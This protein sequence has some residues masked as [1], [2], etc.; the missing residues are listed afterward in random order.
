MCQ[1]QSKVDPGVVLGLENRPGRVRGASWEVLGRNGSA[2]SLRPPCLEGVLGAKKGAR[3]DPKG[4]R[5]GR[6]ETQRAGGSESL[7]RALFSAS[8]LQLFL[9]IDFFSISGWF[10]VRF[11]EGKWEG[12]AVKN[13]AIFEVF[14]QCFF[15]LCR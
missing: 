8:S 11:G 1:N 7:P 2:A 12:K 3:R 9:G 4:A 6:R 10:W 15:L 13:K 14:F 5:E